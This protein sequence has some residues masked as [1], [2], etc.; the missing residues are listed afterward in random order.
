MQK[1]SD[2]DR[3]TVATARL[4][5]A[6]G[7]VGKEFMPADVE[8]AHAKCKQN[9]T[10]THRS[11]DDP[12]FPP[13]TAWSHGSAQLTRVAV[14]PNET[15]RAEDEEE[16]EQ[17]A[18]EK[19]QL[20]SEDEL[21]V[22]VEVGRSTSDI[23]NPNMSSLLGGFGDDESLGSE[24]MD[25]DLD[26]T[27]DTRVDTTA[28]YPRELRAS[29]SKSTTN[30]QGQVTTVAGPL[31]TAKKRRKPGSTQFTVRKN[32]RRSH[33]D[34]NLTS[35]QHE[36]E[37]GDDD[38]DEHENAHVV[39]LDLDVDEM[40]TEAV[41][42]METEAES[43]SEEALQQTAPAPNSNSSSVVDVGS[44]GE[45]D[46]GAA[47]IK[48]AHGLDSMYIGGS[49]RFGH[50]RTTAVDV[51]RVDSQS[52]GDDYHTTEAQIKIPKPPVL[53]ENCRAIL[54][55][56]T[57]WLNSECIQWTWQFWACC[58]PDVIVA[59]SLGASSAIKA[60]AT[61]ATRKQGE[62]QKTEKAWGLPFAPKPGQGLHILLAANPTD[63][64]WVFE[65]AWPDV[66][67][68]QVMDS[69][70]GEETTLSMLAKLLDN[71]QSLQQQQQHQEE[72][73]TVREI[74]CVPQLDNVNCGVHC[75]VNG[76]RS[77]MDTPV[78]R[79]ESTSTNPHL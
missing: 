70:R 9:V 79:L 5:F 58:K 38:H 37:N 4:N 35:S 48:A 47:D 13:I 50:H 73:W 44:T 53:D 23:E 75:I 74:R 42:Q 65:A 56:H 54:G 49:S 40:E 10:A 57:A 33:A 17:D 3:L 39:D 31:S 55:D 66:R 41:D 22:E 63:S 68:V 14:E 64:H 6:T 69:W 7:G 59:D 43:E 34:G 27:N 76:I 45:H 12:P 18:S 60:A 2:V 71:K 30:Y 20:E 46:L 25:M 36:D 72:L 16:E 67:E 19:S 29:T 51:V 26:L 62:G 8:T 24:D 32:A 28:I 15:H 78:E 61:T 21:E 1:A 11:G 77:I 52:D